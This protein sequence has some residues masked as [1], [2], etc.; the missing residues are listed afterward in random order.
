MDILKDLFKSKR[1]LVS[2]AGLAA[3]VL[4]HFGFDIDQQILTDLA[5]LIAGWVVGESLR[6]VIKE[7]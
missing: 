5:V 2:L 7:K 6:P 4:G 3:V 1:F